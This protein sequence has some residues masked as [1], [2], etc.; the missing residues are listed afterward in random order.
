MPFNFYFLSFPHSPHFP[1]RGY[2]RVPS[3][4]LKLIPYNLVLELGLEDTLQGLGISSELA[5]TLA[6]LL[7]GHL[8][9][10]EVE[11]ERRFVIDVG[12]LLDVEVLSVLGLELPWHGLG[13]VLELLEQV[14]LKSVLVMYFEISACKGTHGDGKVIA[15]GQ[16]GDLADATERGTHDDGLVAVLLVV[17]E[18]G[19]DAGHSWVLLLGVLLLVGGLE[20]IEDAAD[21]GGDEEGV[22]LSGGN[23]LGKGEHEGKVAVDAVLL[24]EDPGS[25]DTLPCRGDLDQ[26][27]VLGDANGLVE[28]GQVS[29]Y[30]IYSSKVSKFE[31]TSMMCRA[32]STEPLTEK[33]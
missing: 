28:L 19:L 33:E 31:L 20:P 12:L 23:G 25:L 7:D 9:L 30:S 21:E 4:P 27:A 6:Q 10:V 26:N 24:L 8:V 14:G 18:D 22:G 17:V 1:R 32:L 2:S 13:G 5:D 3:L 15:T 16:L 11:A 29:V